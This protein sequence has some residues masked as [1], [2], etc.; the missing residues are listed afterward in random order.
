MATKFQVQLFIQSTSSSAMNENNYLLNA[1]KREKTLM[2]KTIGIGIL[3][4]IEKIEQKFLSGHFY[5]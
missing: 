1:R 5:S 4:E 2:E 3:N